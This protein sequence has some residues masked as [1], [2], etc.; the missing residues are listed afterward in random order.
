MR[1]CTIDHDLRPKKHWATHHTMA[2]A[3]E[4]SGH[5]R[6]FHYTIP[7][8]LE[9]EARKQGAVDECPEGIGNENH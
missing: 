5:M 1:L 4:G 8:E 6:C 7:P 9:A 3:L 2:H